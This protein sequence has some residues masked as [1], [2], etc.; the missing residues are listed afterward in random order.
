MSVLAQVTG[1]G[2]VG[3]AAASV[4]QERDQKKLA[5]AAQQ[6]EAVF[7]TQM[8]KPMTGGGDPEGSED[9]EKMAGSDTMSSYGTEALAKAIAQGGGV[10]IAKQIVHKVG[11]EKTQHAK[12]LSSA[13]GNGAGTKVP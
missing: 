6:F 12:A 5:D 4:A 3:A 10:G 2:V 11:L 9:T 8:L 13:I 1:T 7:L